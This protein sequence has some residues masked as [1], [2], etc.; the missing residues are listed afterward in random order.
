MRQKYLEYVA[1]EA[2]GGC[3]SESHNGIDSFSATVLNVSFWPRLDLDDAVC[4]SGSTLQLPIPM[5]QAMDQF[6]AFYGRMFPERKVGL[7]DTI[8]I[9][10][11]RWIQQQVRTITY[12]LHCA[13]LHAKMLH[14]CVVMLVQ[15]MIDVAVIRAMLA[16]WLAIADTDVLASC[17]MQQPMLSAFLLFC[18][19]YFLLTLLCYVADFFVRLS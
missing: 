6:R 2:R 11:A 5:Q 12:N 8:D 19:P 17:I 10:H 18:F 13:E 7:V 16:C 1:T 14:S 9:K 3:V 4:A 15:T